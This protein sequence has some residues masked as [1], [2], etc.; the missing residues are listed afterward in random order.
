MARIIT[1]QVADPM[2]GYQQNTYRTTRQADAV[3]PAEA[4]AMA[5]LAGEVAD[6]IVEGASRLFETKPELVR[7]GGAAPAPAPSGRIDLPK[8]P[9]MGAP[10]TLPEMRDLNVAADRPVDARTAAME[11]AFGIGRSTVGETV[12]QG[13]LSQSGL[14]EEQLWKQKGNM[15]GPEWDTSNP[16]Y[17]D[18]VLGQN[19]KWAANVQGHANRADAWIA[20]HQPVEP[21]VPGQPQF[22]ESFGQLPR[23]MSLQGK[24][25]GMGLQLDKS[26]IMPDDFIAQMANARI[27]A[28]E[29]PR[30]PATAPAA[31]PAGAA[32]ASQLP[33]LTGS[34]RVGEYRP[35][36]ADA[37]A[38]TV[39]ASSPAAAAPVAVAGSPDAKKRL[40]T[41]DPNRVY[42]YEKE[43]LPMARAIAESGTAEDRADLRAALEQSNGYGIHASSLGGLVRGNKNAAAAEHIEKTMKSSG[44]ML[45]D[46]KAIDLRNKIA[47]HPYELEKLVADTDIK[48]AEAKIRADKAVVS[49]E[50]AMVE[51]ENKIAK[52]DINQS[53]AK[54]RLEKLISEVNDNLQKS[55]LNA[56][57]TDEIRALIGPKIAELWSRVNLQNEKAKTEPSNRVKNYAGAARDRAEAGLAPSKQFRNEHIVLPGS[58]ASGGAGVTQK[59]VTDE[60]MNYRK[61]EAIVRKNSAIA[62]GKAGRAEASPDA[63]ADVYYKKKDLIDALNKLGHK[64]AASVLDKDIQNLKKMDDEFFRKYKIRPG[65]VKDAKSID[66]LFESLGASGT[67]ARI[68]TPDG[69]V[70]P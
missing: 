61:Q 24:P 51:L 67:G 46:L 65:D 7:P 39:G 56:A 26:Y 43:L 69:V 5:R 60:L 48:E 52:R 62:A 28:A 38:R 27:D 63:T 31:A 17:R 19:Q 30:A 11:Q 70:T 6:P 16:T 22:G 66:G 34:H 8:V 40:F 13:P 45:D 55:G 10:T 23:G 20:R 12:T 53:E 37:P 42:H 50:S 35:A 32:G 3:S 68:L 58:G 29:P 44:S 54:V 2:A 33:Q 36:F 4:L 64:E 41:L 15:W 9:H 18:D 25:A 57:K 21:P 1:R 59:I 49:A 47:K 14:E